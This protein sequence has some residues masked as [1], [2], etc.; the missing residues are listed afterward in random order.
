M[1][2]PTVGVRIAGHPFVAGL[3]VL[4]CGPFAAFCALHGGE[5]MIPAIIL[6][7]VMERVMRAN[8]AVMKYRAWRAAWDSMGDDAPRRKR[9]L[10]IARIVVFVVGGLFAAAHLDD[11][12]IQIAM[13]LI[14]LAFTLLL[15]AAIFRRLGI[16]GLWRRQAS[17][18]DAVA[19]VVCRPLMPVP[20]LEQAFRAL[21]EHCQRL[22]EGRPL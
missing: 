22:R 2:A 3:V 14:G 15:G 7:V 19:I 20:S 8:E 18:N 5:G 6:A 1:K 13:A 4:V 9:G 12:Q 16:G 21:P 10:A 11:P 17:S